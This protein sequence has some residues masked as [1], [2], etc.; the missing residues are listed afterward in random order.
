MKSNKTHA[1]LE[2]NSR[3]EKARQIIGIIKDYKNIYEC[4]ILDIGTGSGV[5]PS[6]IGKLCKKMHS[7]DLEDERIARK[8]YKFI[9]VKDERLPFDD[10]SFD[11]VISNHVMAH[12]KDQNIHLEQINR[13]LKKDGIAYLSALNRLNPIEPNYNLPFLSFLP[14]KLADSY[15]RLARKKGSY[16]VKPLTYLGFVKKLERYFNY[17]DRTLNL[18][19]QKLRMPSMAYRALR[20]F[21]PVWIFVLKKKA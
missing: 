4:T 12:V 2:I 19:R 21:S 11:V 20:I 5:I 9:K 7:V 1:V 13:V 3:K 6:E 8:N 15:V 17:E 18:I 10:E 16:D 14:K